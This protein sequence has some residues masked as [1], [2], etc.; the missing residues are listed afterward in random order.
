M[1]AAL[2]GTVVYGKTTVN[3]LNGNG[4]YKPA[5]GGQYVSRYPKAAAIAFIGLGPPDPNP[6]STKIPMF[7]EAFGGYDFR[8]CDGLWLPPSVPTVPRC[9]V[10]RDGTRR[11]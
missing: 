7:V 11:R 2:P 10:I 1:G 5:S 3:R 8:L 4:L 6:A 9:P